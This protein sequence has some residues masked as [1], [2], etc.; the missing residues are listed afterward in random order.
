LRRIAWPITLIAALF[1]AGAVTM[2]YRGVDIFGLVAAATSSLLQAPATLYLLPYD[3]SQLRIGDTKKIDIVV[4]AREPINAIGATIKFPQ[5][6]MEVLGFSK[7]KSFF[8]LWTEETAINEDNGE[9]HFSGGTI[10]PGGMTGTGTVLT[11]T[12]RPKKSG[13]QS[14]FFKDSQVYSADGKGTQL[15]NDVHSL[16]LSV[17]PQTVAAN[18]SDAGAA[19]SSQQPAAKSADLNNDGAVN[20][21]D[22]SIMILR[23]MSRQYDQRFDLNMDGVLNIGDLSVLLSKI[24]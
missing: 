17:L 15:D 18:S 24:H 2:T 19:P 9:I 20:I 8:D 12:I 6:S 22:M 13:T 23:L 4:T 10:K 5:D 11:L 7:E 1:T 21:V 16:S 14:L 3:D